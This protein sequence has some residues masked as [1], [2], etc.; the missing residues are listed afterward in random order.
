ML[1]YYVQVLLPIG[2]FIFIF[3]G[4]GR[5]LAFV[6][7]TRKASELSEGKAV[8]HILFIWYVQKFQVA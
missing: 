3:Y 4:P 5:N 6:V 1:F 7:V 8:A 2:L